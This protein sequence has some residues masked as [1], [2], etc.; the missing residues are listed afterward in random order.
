MGML[1]EYFFFFFLLAFTLAS[2]KEMGENVKSILIH[3]ILEI[4]SSI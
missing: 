2:E 3:L 4:I 1:F